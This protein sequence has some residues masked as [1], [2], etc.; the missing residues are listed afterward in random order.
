MDF[1]GQVLLLKPNV[2]IEMKSHTDSKGDDAYNLELSHKR[3]QAAEAYLVAKGVLKEQVFGVGY[4]EKETLNGCVN[5]VTCTEA[6]HKVNR[7]IE[8]LVIEDN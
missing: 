3:A 4:G 8:F 7:R 5:G 2:K 1:I 6:Q